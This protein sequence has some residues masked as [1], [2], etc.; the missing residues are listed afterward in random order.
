[1]VREW[2]WAADPR[3][4]R[5]PQSV[6]DAAREWLERGGANAWPPQDEEQQDAATRPEK[7]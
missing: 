4:R 6:H 5:L 3:V 7:E 1:M 2:D